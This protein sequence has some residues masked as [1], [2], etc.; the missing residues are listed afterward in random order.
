MN[1]FQ[2]KVRLYGLGSGLSR[3]NIRPG[4]P[5]YGHPAP[6][7]CCLEHMPYQRS[8]KKNDTETTNATVAER[9]VEIDEKFTPVPYSSSN[10]AVNS[11]IG[12]KYLLVQKIG[13]KVQDTAR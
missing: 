8:Q 10:I 11:V 12:A 2:N 4:P 6:T 7:Y 1:P 3:R 13:P 5:F 9:A